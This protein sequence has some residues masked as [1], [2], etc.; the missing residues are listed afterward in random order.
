[1]G[2]LSSDLAAAEKI[3]NY[4]ILGPPIAAGGLARVYKVRAED[5]KVRAAKILSDEFFKDRKKKE[6]VSS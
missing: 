2:T 3:G 5:G 6:R 1:M 4:E